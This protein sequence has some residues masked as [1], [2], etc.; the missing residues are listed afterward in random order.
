MTERDLTRAHRE[1]L[2]AIDEAW[3]V[4]R[5]RDLI[6]VPSVTGSDA[7]SE[8][9]NWMARDFAEFGLDVDLWKLDLA[10]LESDPAYPGVEAERSEGYGL[11]GVT[12]GEGDIGFV[13]QGH[14]DVVPTGDLA[15]WDLPNPFSGDIV[16]DVLHGRGACD[17]KAGVVANMAVARALAASGV[18]FEKRF[19]LHQVVSE[20]DGGLGAF[21]TLRRGHTGETC[22]ITEPTSG[23][24]VVANA[25][26]LTFEIRVPGRAAHGS[27]RHEGVSAFEAFWPIHASLRELEERINANPHPLYADNP[28]PYG[29][30]I[31]KIRAGDWA[32]SVPDLLVAEG[33]LGV[34]LDADPADARRQ[35]EEAVADAC[36]RDP[37]L[38]DHPATV[39]WTGG[40]FAPGRL[41]H[42][43][44]LIGEMA[45]AVELTQGRRPDLGA[46]PY[47]S[48]LR[49]YVGIGGIATLHYGPGDV[50]LAHAPR[51]RVR[52]GEMFEV[53]RALAVLAVDRLGARL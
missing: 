49:L 34:P 32:S 37:W 8:L 4:S 51:E 10:D 14:I 45:D 25:G 11:V 21:A 3:M 16:G 31:G 20:E 24:I 48:D 27:T 30:S 41:G 53:T 38:K 7:E 5:L 35:F 29:I 39:A 15:K 17:M 6:T 40:Q 23:R 42:D 26:A 1:V 28:L 2:D 36:R 43:H 13:L 44:P 18:R 33:R 50:R 19:A 47:G 9:Q 52:L 46:A 22:V 12:P